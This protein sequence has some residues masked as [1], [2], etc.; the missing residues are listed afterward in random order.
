MIDVSRL[1]KV[2]ISMG[3]TLALVFS[4]LVMEVPVRLLGGLL[5]MPI[6]P[7]IIIFLYGNY[8]PEALPAP[9][10]FFCGLLHDLLYGA[11]LGVW[12]SAYL[13]LHFLV[14]SQSDYLH[15]RLQRVVWLAFSVAVLGVGGLIWVEQSLLARGW[16]PMLPLIY[17]L[18]M[19]IAVYRL[20]AM[21]FFYLRE[22]AA[23][24][25]GAA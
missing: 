10:L 2:L 23:R 12:P 19:T 16:L 9:V 1:R 17:Q 18:F 21:L 7:F 6:L 8:E 13:V 25:P 22:R 3:P 15:G 20:A 14:T 11:A 5:P 4:I 24:A